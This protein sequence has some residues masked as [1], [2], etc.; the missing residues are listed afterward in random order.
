MALLD[1][2]GIYI[3]QKDCRNDNVVGLWQKQACTEMPQSTPT[4][5]TLALV[6][7]FIILVWPM[8]VAIKM[9]SAVMVT[10]MQQP[11]RQ[12]LKIHIL[13]LR[14]SKMLLC[15]DR[16]VCTCP[17]YRW[18]NVPDYIRGTPQSACSEYASGRGGHV[19]CADAACRS[20]LFPM[21]G[22]F[23]D[24]QWQAGQLTSQAGF[25]PCGV[26]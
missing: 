10:R 1:K 22:P 14:Y 3:I 15:C 25:Q 11:L 17:L 20:S 6:F 21:S 18:A 5:S 16:T 12:L 9:L 23:S 7:E 2:V 19:H 13:P 4:R 26:Q 24:A 8:H